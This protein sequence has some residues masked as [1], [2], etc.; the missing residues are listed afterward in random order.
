MLGSEE[1]AHVLMAGVHRD[2]SLVKRWIFGYPTRLGSAST[3][4]FH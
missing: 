4:L 2:A 3:M 1:P